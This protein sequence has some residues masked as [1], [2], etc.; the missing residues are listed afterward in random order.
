MMDTGRLAET[1]WEKDEE[2]KKLQEQV[3]DR[4]VIEDIADAFGSEEGEDFD[5]ESEI[6][7]LQQENEN[8]DDEGR[9]RHEQEGLRAKWGRRG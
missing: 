9:Q 6:H 8:E 5:W 4:V 7:E 1:I 2:I 3:N